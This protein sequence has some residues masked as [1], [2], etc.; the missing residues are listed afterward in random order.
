MQRADGD[1]EGTAAGIGR[2]LDPERLLD[3]AH[4]LGVPGAERGSL[5][6]REFVDESPAEELSR[7]AA[8][9]R[10]VA[11]A[12]RHDPPVGIEDRHQHPGDRVEH[13]QRERRLVAG[14]PSRRLRIGLASRSIDERRP[15]AVVHG[16]GGGE[17]GLEFGP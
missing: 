17:P 16:H 1:V 8:G 9:E 7:G 5:H 15:R 3:P 6:R 4:R 12:Q 13:V 2:H 10:L 14:E 11:G